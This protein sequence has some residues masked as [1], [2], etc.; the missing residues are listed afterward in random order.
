MGGWDRPGGA[1]RCRAFADRPGACA[2][3]RIAVLPNQRCASRTVS[4]ILPAEVAVIGELRRIPG[5][6][7]D[8]GRDASPEGEQ[9]SNGNHEHPRTERSQSPGTG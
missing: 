6:P 2:R 3:T 8:P 9:D 4:S 7:A 1:E 5:V